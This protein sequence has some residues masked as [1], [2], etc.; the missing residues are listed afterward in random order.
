M[1]AKTQNF[2]KTREYNFY[3][4]LLIRQLI[5]FLYLKMKLRQ[6]NTSVLA[7][8]VLCGLLEEIF[9]IFLSLFYYRLF[10]Y[11]FIMQQNNEYTHYKILIRIS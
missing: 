2:V 4:L 6:Q 8:L 10:S 11:H 1:L 9:S 3:P 5:K 7:D